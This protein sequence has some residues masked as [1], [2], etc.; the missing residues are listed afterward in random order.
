MTLRGARDLYTRLGNIRA[1]AR[2][3]LPGLNRP[4]LKEMGKKSDAKQQFAEAADIC[5][6]AQNICACQSAW[7]EREREREREKFIDSQM[8]D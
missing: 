2:G 6:Q 5:R 7:R 1:Q 3:R 4:S 8:N